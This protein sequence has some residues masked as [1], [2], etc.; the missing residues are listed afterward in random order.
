[1]IRGEGATN[2]IRKLRLAFLLTPSELARLMR[3][4]PSDIER[5][6][7]QKHPLAEEWIR[8]VSRALG[9]PAEGITAPNIS[10]SAVK[11]M[12][13]GFAVSP[14]ACPIG[15]RYAISAILAKFGGAEF[16]AKIDPDD[17][18]RLIQNFYDFVE[19]DR[20]GNE[21]S[22]LNRRRLALQITVLTFLQSRDFEPGPT[23]QTDL[24]QAT[25][26]A[27]ALMDRFS[28]ICRAPE[29]Q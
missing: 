21:K 10:T 25:A 15:A 8:S 22:E 4:E 16:A 6:E 12:S 23:F 1:M 20:S 13:K 17:L 29:E 24:E 28:A 18:A 11:Q 2:N 5:I 26:G 14:N 7:T 9:V 27:L 19:N 3:A